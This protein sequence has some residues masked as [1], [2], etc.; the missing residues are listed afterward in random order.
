MKKGF[1]VFLVIGV[2]WTSCTTV[3]KG[4]SATII[5]KWIRELPDGSS[6]MFEITEK[7][8]KVTISKDNR[9]LFSPPSRRYSIKGNDIIIHHGMGV[10]NI[11]N[12]EIINPNVIRLNLDVDRLPELQRVMYKTIGYTEEMLKELALPF[13]LTRFE[14]V[15]EI[16]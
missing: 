12:F 2:L 3:P 8:W 15:L 9:L 11:F 14:P 6:E 1:L 7:E 5:G 4:D 16:V 10:N 13:E